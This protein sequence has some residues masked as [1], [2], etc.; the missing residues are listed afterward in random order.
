MVT[1]TETNQTETS[2]TETSQANDPPKF[3][4]ALVM[5]GAV[6]AGAYTQ[7][8]LDFLFEALEAWEEA[9]AA[10][11][12]S[13]PKPNLE[14]KVITGASAGGICAAMLALRS[15]S[16]WEPVRPSG[17]SLRE[18][19]VYLHD[20]LPQDWASNGQNPG[21]DAWVKQIDILPLLGLTDLPAMPEAQVWSLLDST[22]L[23]AIARQTFATATGNRRRPYWAPQV[24]LAL[25]LTSHLGAP[26]DLKFPGTGQGQFGM[27]RHADYARFC[28]TE[29]GAGQVG[30]LQASGAYTLPLPA[31]P[32]PVA[33]LGW[34]LLQEA[35]LATSAFPAGLRART[36]DRRLAAEWNLRNTYT[37][38][39]P[40]TDCHCANAQLRQ[41][42]KRPPTWA[43]GDA[44][45]YV[46][47]YSD[48]GVLNNEPFDLA[49]RLLLAGKADAAFLEQDPA[50]AWG[51]VL[52][53]DPFGIGEPFDPKA[54]T[55]PATG[56]ANQAHLDLLHLAPSLFTAMRRQNLYKPDV[57]ASAANPSDMRRFL[58]APK[59][60]LLVDKAANTRGLTAE[61]VGEPSLASTALGAFGGFLFEAYRVHD[62]QLGRHNAYKFFSEHFAMPAEAAAQNPLFAGRPA[63]GAEVPLLPLYG[64][65]A[66]PI[67][68]MTW[69]TGLR[70]KDADR[71]ELIF[72]LAGKRANALLDRILKRT[73]LKDGPTWSPRTWLR[74]LR[75][76]LVAGVENLYLRGKIRK[77]LRTWVDEQLDRY[78]L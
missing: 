26:F 38:L 62:Y 51:T 73:G 77:A 40:A 32:G 63:A 53:I 15:A 57:L 55:D 52:M 65:A 8:V 49:E 24:Q 25:T 11:P 9:Y 12:G 3:Q 18:Q 7:G 61:S 39:D 46:S 74:L 56:R 70:T 6:S 72:N 42:H 27:R 76:P 16:R 50:K 1:Q 30:L 67:Y 5:A 47:L 19:D 66:Q 22:A 75:Y 44:D 69:P 28:L 58:I 17:Q 78:N 14:I 10:N 34:Q 13:V 48:G 2:Q 68:P 4:L 60:K 54:A 35:A 71:Y 21:Y 20:Y 23:D 37:Q 59:R 64:T 41:G 36:I 45:P 31:Q 29:A 43:L 33:G